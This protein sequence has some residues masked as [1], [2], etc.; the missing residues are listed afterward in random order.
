MTREEAM[1][2]LG[3]TRGS[4]VSAAFRKLS[5]GCHPDGPT[6]DPVQWDRITMAKT[7]ILAPAKCLECKGSG[8]IVTRVATLCPTCGG[9][10]WLS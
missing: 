6:P 3:V 2:V 1:K 10:G 8:R 9:K 5:V 7:V 4:E